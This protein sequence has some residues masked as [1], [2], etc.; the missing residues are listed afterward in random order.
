MGGRR[1]HGLSL[2]WARRLGSAVYLPKAQ[3][4]DWT[5]EFQTNTFW[6]RLAQSNR[7]RRPD[8]DGVLERLTIATLVLS[9][10]CQETQLKGRETQRSS[11]DCIMSKCAL[12]FSNSEI[13]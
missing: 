7:D 8:S 11:P 9:Y 12:I 4:R 5:R 6:K 1:R 13:D 3:R 10:P 2:S